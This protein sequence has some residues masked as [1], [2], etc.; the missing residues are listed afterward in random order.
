[1]E[2]LIFDSRPVLRNPIL[3]LAF[4]GWSDA[5]AAATTATRYLA[6][7]LMAKKFAAIDPEEFYD[8]YRQ[9][10]VVRLNESKVREI[11]WPSYDF[12]SGAGIG[13]D[14]DFIL[15]IGIEPHLRW[16]TFT[17]TL[18]RFAREVLFESSE[19]PLRQSLRIERLLAALVLDTPEA[20]ERIGAFLD[21]KR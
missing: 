14:R 19:G 11:H 3:V 15:G 16:R 5:G 2:P 6:D 12:Y 9:R 1:M 18:L 13:I 21:R 7:Q 20:H 10:P 4:A 8:F 17:E